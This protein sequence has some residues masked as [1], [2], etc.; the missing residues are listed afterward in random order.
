M[1]LKP[2]NIKQIT[3]ILF[4][5]YSKLIDKLINRQKKKIIQ[6]TYILMC[7]HMYVCEKENSAII[8]IKEN[9]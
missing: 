5:N 4:E 6:I 3:K 8:Q 2:T 7:V 1:L 9:I